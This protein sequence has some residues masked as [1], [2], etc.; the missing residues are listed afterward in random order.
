MIE[1]NCTM[2]A[3]IIWA[4]LQ[5]TLPKFM[6]FFFFFLNL[7]RDEFKAQEAHPVLQYLPPSMKI[8]LYYVFFNFQLDT[9]ASTAL[10]IRKVSI[11][12][13][14]EKKGAPWRVCPQI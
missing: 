7:Q 11:T 10:Q 13:N 14:L 2:K 1:V 4:I 6:F 9:P 12:E 8:N 5:L 3:N